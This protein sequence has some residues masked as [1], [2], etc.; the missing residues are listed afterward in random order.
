M[1]SRGKLK[2]FKVLRAQQRR[3]RPW[4]H[5][6]GEQNLQATLLGC[7]NQEPEPMQEP[8]S[9]S[10]EKV[11]RQHWQCH[12]KHEIKEGIKWWKKALELDWKYKPSM[13]I[14]QWVRI[15]FI[16][17]LRLKKLIG[18]Y[19]WCFELTGIMPKWLDWFLYA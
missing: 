7:P 3:L 1:D 5:E 9:K 16:Q 11:W 13:P 18:R 12:R 17:K 8:S 6:K 4:I 10:N 2:I 19:F 15:G 14:F